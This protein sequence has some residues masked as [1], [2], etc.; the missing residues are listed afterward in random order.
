M[1]INLSTQEV[2]YKGIYFPFKKVKDEIP[3]T[4]II[5]YRLGKPSLGNDMSVIYKH[6]WDAVLYDFKKSGRLKKILEKILLREGI[7]DCL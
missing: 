4:D 3:L 5:S 2:Y 6:A 7:E 1:K